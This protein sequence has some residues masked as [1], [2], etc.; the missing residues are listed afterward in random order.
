MIKTLL[1]L[2]TSAVAVY[3]LATA[4]E[5]FGDAEKGEKV[6]RKCK[7]CHQVGEDAKNKTGPQLNGIIG[8]AAGAVEGFKYSSAM[9]DAGAGGLKWTPEDLL[10]FLTKPKDY[11]KGTKMAFAGIRKEKQRADILAYLAT[12]E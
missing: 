6:F 2:L 11:M 4:A 3:P 12:F 7:A 5:S 9:A 1:F 8:R 10:A